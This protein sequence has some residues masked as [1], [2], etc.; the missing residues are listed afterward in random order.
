MCKNCECFYC[1]NEIE[2][3]E[4]KICELESELEDSKWQETV[5]KETAMGY[6]LCLRSQ[7]IEIGQLKAKATGLKLAIIRALGM[8]AVE[9]GFDF[10]HITDYLDQALVDAKDV[11]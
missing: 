7:Q 6:N 1:E 11:A 5:A 10:W 3:L 4:T 8:C 9:P 2:R